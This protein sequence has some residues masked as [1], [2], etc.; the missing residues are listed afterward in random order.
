MDQPLTNLRQTS[1]T[2]RALLENRSK[3][4]MREAEIK[5]EELEM[6]NRELEKLT[7]KLKKREGEILSLTSSKV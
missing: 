5:A 1:E 4:L 7:E 3:E 6:T 2:E